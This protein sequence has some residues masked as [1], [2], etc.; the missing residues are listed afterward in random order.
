MALAAAYF[1]TGGG[2][3]EYDALRPS[4]SSPTSPSLFASSHH[5]RQTVT[6]FVPVNDDS[7]PIGK[8]GG[9][10]MPSGSMPIGRDRQ[11]RSFPVA[12]PD[13]DTVFLIWPQLD[14]GGSLRS[15]LAGLCRKVCAVGHSASLVQM[16]VEDNPPVPNL[17]P[18]ERP[19][20]PMRL[21]VPWSGR[22]HELETRYNAELRP[23]PAGWKGYAEPTKGT[24][25]PAP[26]GTVF[27]ADLVVLRVVEGSRPLGLESTLMLTEALRGA[28]MKSCPDPP[29]EWISGHASPQGP[30]S[31]KPHIAFAPLAHVGREHADGHLLGIALAVPKG[32]S[33]GGQRECLSPLVFGE[34]GLARAIRLTLGSVGVWSAVLDDREDRPWTLR[35]EAWTGN[36]A[37]GYETWATVTPIVLDRYPKER[38][39]GAEPTVSKRLSQNRALGSWNPIQARGASTS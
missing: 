28:A 13:S 19:G 38:Q 21:R 9:A 2:P 17:A 10:I 22:L 30:P 36:P 25:I 35:P 12:I 3:D 23:T 1:E 8:K 16:W 15:A 5:R 4:S 14:V 27:S 20:A 33:D 11:P 31:Q 18:T 7:S 26:S 39:A 37:Q 29:P 32:V 24:P 34:S 6:T